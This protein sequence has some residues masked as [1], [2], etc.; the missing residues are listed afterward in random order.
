MAEKELPPPEIVTDELA[1]A[2]ERHGFNDDEPEAE[3]TASRSSD[4]DDSEG[5]RPHKEPLPDPISPRQAPV[6]EVKPA[7]DSGDQSEESKE[8]L[9]EQ[10]RT[11]EEATALAD[12]LHVL[13]RA[14]TLDSTIEKMSDEEILAQAA[15]VR[16]LQSANDDL[17]RRL[18]TEGALEPTDS[19]GKSGEES[20]RGR[21]PSDEQPRA[22]N[23]P[24][25]KPALLESL[26]L[27]G[28]ENAQK[29]LAEYGKSIADATARSFEPLRNEV[30]FLRGEVAAS[31]GESTRQ[32]LVDSGRYPQFE[33]LGKWAAVE[34]KGVELLQ[35]PAYAGNLR[36]ALGDAVRIEAGLGRSLPSPEERTRQAAARRNGNP[37][38]PTDSMSEGKRSSTDILDSNIDKSMEARGLL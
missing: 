7:K 19:G 21:E 11:E 35:S 10:G 31:V 12:A 15:A 2:F 9:P 6:S 32:K 37:D 24:E 13:R 36:K 14:K 26:G 23:L 17:S 25:V 27:E 28:D 22:N 20:S 29:A 33:D 3:Q 8:E 1:D 5:K 4:L 34:A 16:P 30:S 38:T 18:G